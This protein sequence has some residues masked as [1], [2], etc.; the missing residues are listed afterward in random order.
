MNDIT[1]LIDEI[2][3][4]HGG[5]VNLI[6]KA[7]EL[8]PVRAFPFRLP[9]LDIDMGGGVLWGKETIV[10]GAKGTGKTTLAYILAANAQ[11]HGIPVF[12]LDLEKSFDAE[13]SKVFGVDP[14]NIYVIRDEL[15]AERAFEVLRDLMTTINTWDDTR[16]LFVVDS[17]ALMVSEA[18]FEKNASQQFG[19]SARMINQAVSVWNLKL[20]ENQILF[21]INELRS[22]LGSMGE[23]EMMP[24]GMA[25]E[26]LASSIVWL[27]DGETLKDGNKAIGKQLRWTIKKSRS[28]SP[29]E[30]GQAEF[31]YET[32]FDVNRNI[33]MAAIELELIEQ[34]GPYY[35]FNGEKFR[36][37]EALFEKLNTDPQ[38]FEVLNTEIYK[39]MNVPIWDGSEE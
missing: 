33:L 31:N 9:T 15:T 6:R 14:D 28:S 37:K 24:G 10:A 34:A 5:K 29:K 7:S 30:I 3:K 25:Q 11:S 20:R 27:R 8:P 4:K 36:G 12:W 32:G 38:F 16:A 21:M 23:P 19:G 2:N 39:H 35:S 22:K 17:I 26:F 18:L 1:R 13:R